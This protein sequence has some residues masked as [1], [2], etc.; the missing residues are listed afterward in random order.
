MIIYGMKI[1]SDLEFDL[2]LPNDIIYKDTFVLSKNIPSTLKYNLN[3]NTLLHTTKMHKVYLSSNQ[4]TSQKPSRNQIFCYEIEGIAKFYWYHQDKTIYYEFLDQD[5]G[6]FTFWF[7]HYFFS[8]FLSIE[9]YAVMIHASAVEIDGKS[10]LFLAPYKSGK[11]TLAH[12]ITKQG[13][14]LITDDILATF[15]QDNKLYYHPSHPYTNPYRQNYSLGIKVTNYKTTIDTIDMI[16]VLQNSFEDIPIDIKPLYGIEKF[17]LVRKNSLLYTKKYIRI[18]HEK[19]LQKLLENTKVFMIKRP[20]GT[21]HIP[22]LYKAIYKHIKQEDGT[23][24]S[25]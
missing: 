5:I 11:S 16:Y 14:K 22:L 4:D 15:I 1:I 25:S 6:K 21:Q 10:I 12:Y 20:W 19:H 7:I 3:Y 24:P 23:N 2:D 9:S 18:T 17:T 13:H 8:F